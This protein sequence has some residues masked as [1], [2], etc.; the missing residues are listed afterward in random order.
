MSGEDKE[1]YRSEPGRV[2]QDSR[3][4]SVSLSVCL[5]VSLSPCLLQV[6]FPP[7]RVTAEQHNIL[8]RIKHHM[9]K[10]PVLKICAESALLLKSDLLTSNRRLLWETFTSGQ[11]GGGRRSSKGGKLAAVSPSREQVHHPS[12]RKSRRPAGA[13]SARLY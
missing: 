6:V 5:Y 12:V 7:A 9:W 10:S 13:T 8:T 3:C 1:N 11:K 4:V 2:G